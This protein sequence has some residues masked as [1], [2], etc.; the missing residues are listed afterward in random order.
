MRPWCT[1]LSCIYPW[2]LILIHACMMHISMF[3]DPWLWCMYVWWGVPWAWRSSRTRTLKRHT[4]RLGWI[5]GYVLKVTNWHWIFIKILNLHFSSLYKWNC[6]FR[7]YHW[8]F[9]FRQDSKDPTFTDAQNLLI[10]HMAKVLFCNFKHW[11]QKT[12][13]IPMNL[14]CIY[15]QYVQYR[16]NCESSQI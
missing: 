8:H 3:L 13:S 5:Y 6:Q 11:V 15:A 9:H 1:Y 16:H 14:I 7:H 12:T 10:L 4:M 2:C